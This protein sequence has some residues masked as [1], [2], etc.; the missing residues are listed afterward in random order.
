FKF[1]VGNIKISDI[2]MEQ[3]R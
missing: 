3:S 2:A 1:G